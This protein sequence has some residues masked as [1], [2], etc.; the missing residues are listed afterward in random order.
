MRMMF[1]WADHTQKQ[2]KRNGKEAV[3]NASIWLIIRR[4]T[5]ETAAV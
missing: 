5:T 2:S 3:A 4:Q 1:P